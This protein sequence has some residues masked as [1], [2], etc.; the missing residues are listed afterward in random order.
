MVAVVVVMAAVSAVISFIVLW[1][2]DADTS[3][4]A[5]GSPSYLRP[6]GP[7]RLVGS[8]APADFS[9]AGPSLPG[10][11]PATVPDSRIQVDIAVKLGEMGLPVE[12]LDITVE[13]RF[14]TLEGRV[15]DTLLRDAIEV[16]VRSVEGVR[17][18]DNQLEVIQTK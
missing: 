8:M 11:D 2:D 13:D 4:K 7:V 15:E 9:E 14:V 16:A 18:V 10:R 5:A 3:L 17:E 6:I 12:P 1:A